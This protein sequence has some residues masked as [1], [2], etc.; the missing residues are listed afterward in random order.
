MS[1]AVPHD[2]AARDR[3]SGRAISISPRSAATAKMPWEADGR[4]WHTQECVSR[5]GQPCRWDGQIL[6][7]VVDRIHEL[8]QFSPTD[9]NNRS[10]VEIS[11][12]EKIRRLVFPRH[13]GEQWLLKLKFRVARNTFQRDDLVDRLW[14]KP[15]NEIADLPVYGNGPRVQCKSLRGPWQEVQLHVHAHGGNR[16]ARVLAIPRAGRRRLQSIHRSRAAAARGRDAVES[17]GAEMALCAQGISAGQ[18]SRNG[19]S[20]CSKSCARCWPAA[21]PGGQFLWN[22]Q[23][24]V[25]ML[26]RGQS[27]PWATIHTKRLDAVYLQLTG[28][29][30]RFALG[31][32]TELGSDRNLDTTSPTFDRIHIVLPLP[33]PILANGDLPALLREHFAAVSRRQRPIRRQKPFSQNPHASKKPCS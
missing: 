30:N 17:A 14:L 11:G 6:A 32:L 2:F 22:N 15:L 13:H 5:N 18:E 29:K 10:V 27:E 21:A 9:W 28:P 3:P 12:A 16:S 25:H 31:Q 24:I 23:Q 20:K 7:R 26:V 1:S 4:R 19:K 33:R 8:G